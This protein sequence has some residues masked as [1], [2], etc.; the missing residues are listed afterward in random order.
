M[1]KAQKLRCRVDVPQLLREPTSLIPILV[2]VGG[3]L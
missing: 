1:R 3:S 2:L